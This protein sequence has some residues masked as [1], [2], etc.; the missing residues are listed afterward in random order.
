MRNWSKNEVVGKVTKSFESSY[1]K[2]NLLCCCN[3][4]WSLC[5]NCE[6]LTWPLYVLWWIYLCKRWCKMKSYTNTNTWSSLLMNL[7][8]SE[9]IRSHRVSYMS[10]VISRI[11]YNVYKHE[12]CH[13]NSEEFQGEVLLWRRWDAG[14]KKK[15]RGRILQQLLN[16]QLQT[17]KVC[18]KE[19]CQSQGLLLIYKSGCLGNKVRRQ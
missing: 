2:L 10:P 19:M 6:G 4:F 13:L 3:A 8:I 17:Q 9:H 18:R 7:K 1:W 12:V 16:I 15:H 5:C 14:K 11:N